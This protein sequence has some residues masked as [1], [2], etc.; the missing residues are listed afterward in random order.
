M[1]K[2]R[3]THYHASLLANGWQEANHTEFWGYTKT[4]GDRLYTI[5]ASDATDGDEFDFSRVYVSVATVGDPDD[6]THLDNV[7]FDEAITCVR[8]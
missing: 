7:P 3:K 2:F 1:D 5:T 4:I 8:G 6:E